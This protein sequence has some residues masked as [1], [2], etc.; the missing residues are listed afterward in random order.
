MFSFWAFVAQSAVGV[1]ET[2]RLLLYVQVKP[3]H[4]DREL[5]KDFFSKAAISFAIDI[6][7]IRSFFSEYDRFFQ[8]TIVFSRIRWVDKPGLNRNTQISKMSGLMGNGR[9]K[10]SKLIST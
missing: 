7:R 2:M 6:F 8:N 1:Y 5:P 10:T 4:P 3:S 9:T